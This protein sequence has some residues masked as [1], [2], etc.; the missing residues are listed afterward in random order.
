MDDN[1]N[2][3]TEE[4]LMKLTVLQLRDIARKNGI[5]VSGLIRKKELV[6]KILS[7]GALIKPEKATLADTEKAAHDVK[8]KRE[9]SEAKLDKGVPHKKHRLPDEKL[10]EM[11]QYIS[12][13]MSNKPSFFAIDGKLEAAA[14]KYAEKNYYAALKEIQEARRIASDVYSH[15]RLFTNAL[16][17]DAAEKAL[18]EA[19]RRGA[20]SEEKSEQ[21]LY[22]AMD[23]FVNGTPA[24]RE[25][26]LE[27]L[28]KETIAA[29]DK[30]MGDV[31]TELEMRK[32][33][34]EE[35]TAMGAN[36]IEVSG[37]LAN[38]ESLVSALRLDEAKERVTKAAELLRKLE[39]A[40]MEEIKYHI[41]R[42]R[43]SIDE[44]R[45]LGLDVKN[46]EQDLQK[47][48]YDFERGE[49]RQCVD[50]LIRAEKAVDGIVHEALAANPALRQSQL[51][52][53]KATMEK[54]LPFLSEAFSYGIDASEAQHYL[55]NTRMALER[56]DALS[57]PKFVR[58]AENLSKQYE[59]EIKR[60]KDGSRH[61]TGVK[62]W[63]CNQEMLYDYPNRIRRCS[64]C[65][66]FTRNPS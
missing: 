7:A 14:L 62:C 38:A 34:A 65:G 48:S 22:A 6:D 60:L 42:V 18:A 43:T 61:A 37:I 8:E 9:S 11:R 1:G 44:A 3:E 24:V 33:K 23:G 47:A 16:G 45:S 46:A 26:T 17:I 59:E 50:E 35:L 41:P 28:E 15:F 66:W 49:L 58:R 51:D 12:F 31:R 56:S 32:K 10:A 4:E 39:I 13:M 40:K 29:F 2:R 5:D 54:L 53:A 55:N 25:G 19:I 30:M 36:V 20:I 57:A 63:Q 52:K 21:L 64:N 27:K